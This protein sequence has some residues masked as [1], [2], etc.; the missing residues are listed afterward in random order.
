M[1]VYLTVTQRLTFSSGKGSSPCRWAKEGLE[2]AK[3]G[4]DK[5]S[6]AKGILISSPV[7]HC[8][9]INLTDFSKMELTFCH[10]S[11]V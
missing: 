7:L 2:T 6:E 11:T 9:L 5:E 10:S 1:S 4:G 8:I 3:A